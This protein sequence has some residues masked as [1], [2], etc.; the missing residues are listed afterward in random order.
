MAPSS[1]KFPFSPSRTLGWSA[2]V[3][4]LIAGLMFATN[5]SL[6]ATPPDER[7]PENLAELVHLERERLDATNSEVEELRSEV[8][9]LIQNQKTVSSP[10]APRTAAGRVAVEGPGVVVKLWDAPARDPLPDGVGSMTSSCT[11]RTSNP[12]STHW[13][14]GAEAWRSRATG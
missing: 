6:F 7:R 12:S 4:G 13:A 10:P 2:G 8:T 3:V 1:R 14:G 9:D 11:S 5:A